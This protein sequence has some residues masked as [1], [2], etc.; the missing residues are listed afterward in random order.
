MDQGLHGPERGAL[1]GGGGLRETGTE[2]QLP[3]SCM[4]WGMAG[5]GQPGSFSVQKDVGNHKNAGRASASQWKSEFLS[6]SGR[7]TQTSRR[8]PHLTTQLQNEDVIKLWPGHLE[9]GGLLLP[10]IDAGQEELQ[11]G[12]D[13]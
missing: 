4:T 2:K 11:R 8:K 6:T 7:L 5:G 12:A 3:P 1:E 10:V 13:T 9:V